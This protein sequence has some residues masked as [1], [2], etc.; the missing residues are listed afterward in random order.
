MQTDGQTDSQR[1]RRMNGL[2]KGVERINHVY[3]MKLKKY[4]IR[5]RQTSK[6]TKVWMEHFCCHL[7]DN[8]KKM[9]NCSES[10]NACE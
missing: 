6:T 5:S 9:S 3:D 7:F 4:K 10:R 8:C 1:M 2:Y